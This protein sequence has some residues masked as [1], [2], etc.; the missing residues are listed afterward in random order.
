MNIS[1]YEID[2]ENV[3]NN[4]LKND[5]K[6]VLLQ[7]P[8]GLKSHFFKFADFI[9]EKTNADVIISADPCFGACDIP[10]YDLKNLGV[11]LIVQ[12]GHTSIPALKNSQIPIIFV[13]AVSILDISN[14]IQRAIPLIKD[15]KVGLVSTAQHVHLLNEAKELLVK[16]KF[17]TFIGRGDTRIKSKGQILGCNFSAAKSIIDK[18]VSL[19]NSYVSLLRARD[20]TLQ[21][22]LI[23]ITLANI[24]PVIY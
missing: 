14:V 8:D 18:I 4:I 2:L 5:Y 10:S 21:K 9:E 13:N 12:I 6:K 15:K 20:L 23:T 22:V 11:E 7:I 1:G 3:V 17:E 16:N 19:D 24:L